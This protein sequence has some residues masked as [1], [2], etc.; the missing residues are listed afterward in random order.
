MPMDIRGRQKTGAVTS[1]FSYVAG[2]HTRGL[3]CCLP[4]VAHFRVSLVPERTTFIFVRG[5]RNVKVFIF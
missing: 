4:D 3:C 1:G 2:A 5:G